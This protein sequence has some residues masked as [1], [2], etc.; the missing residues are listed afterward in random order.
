[1]TKRS[2]A[3]TYHAS[4][5]HEAAMQRAREAGSMALRDPEALRAALSRMA[6]DWL[7]INFPIAVDMSDE[8]FAEL[9]DAA[10]AEF[11]N[12]A[13]EAAN[14]VVRADRSS[15]HKVTATDVSGAGSEFD[16]TDLAASLEDAAERLGDAAD[17]TTM[18]ADCLWL[19]LPEIPVTASPAARL[20][21]NA[22]IRAG[23]RAAVDFNAVHEKYIM[24]A[25]RY[26]S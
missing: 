4:I 10:E 6:L 8:E 18:L 15:R 13:F 3:A 1:M 17:V 7:N 12:S 9:I 5:T 11:L 2:S 22:C 21:A 20:A 19:L 16:V 24:E 14:L 26:E 23:Q 25:E